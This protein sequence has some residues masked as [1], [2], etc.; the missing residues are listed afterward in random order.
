M[1]SRLPWKTQV[2]GIAI[3][4]SLYANQFFICII[5]QKG[6]KHNLS[7]TQWDLQRLFIVGHMEPLK[8]FLS[9]LK[10][11]RW[12]TCLNGLKG[13]PFY[14]STFIRLASAFNQSELQIRS[15]PLDGTIFTAFKYSKRK[16]NC[17][18]NR[19]WQVKFAFQAQSSNVKLQ[20]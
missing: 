12:Q 3:T 2:L 6:Q 13:L 20:S 8:C 9:I 10:M 14:R 16:I 17:I 18:M 7:Y 15:R 19:M 5:I 1:F 11:E 4:F